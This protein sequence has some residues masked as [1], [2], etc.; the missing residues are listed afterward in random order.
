MEDTRVSVDITNRFMVGARG[1]N[2]VVMNPPTRMTE[3][4]G[5]EAMALAAWLVALASM[6]SSQPFQVFYDKVCGT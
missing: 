6:S 4:S 3:M 2:I 5:D 1:R